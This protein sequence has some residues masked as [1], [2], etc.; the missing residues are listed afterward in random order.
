MVTANGEKVTHGHAYQSTTNP[1]G[2]TLPQKIEDL[3]AQA[4]E[5]LIATRPCGPIR[6][7]E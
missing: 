5:G 2:G 6:T 3:K 1:A 7:K 4:A